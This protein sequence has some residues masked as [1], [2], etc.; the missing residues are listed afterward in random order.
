MVVYSFLLDEISLECQRVLK[1]VLLKFLI[2]L[3]IP[4]RENYTLYP[5]GINIYRKLIHFNIN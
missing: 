1:N 2:G 4:F 5:L 3:L